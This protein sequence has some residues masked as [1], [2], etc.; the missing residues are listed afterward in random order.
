MRRVVCTYI[1]KK[2]GNEERDRRLIGQAL[3]CIIRLLRRRFFHFYCV[4]AIVLGSLVS[5]LK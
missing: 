4:P 5:A 1:Y 3:N 2:Y